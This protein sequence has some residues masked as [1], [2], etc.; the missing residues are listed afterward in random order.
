[1]KTLVC[2][3]IHDHL[4]HFE[5]VMEAALAADCSSMICCGDL[6]SPF[7]IDLIHSKW[8]GPVHIIF[9][10]ND[11]DKLTIYQKAEKANLERSPNAAI[12]IHGEFI[13]SRNGNVLDGIPH[14]ISI[15]VYHFPQPAL[16]MAESGL[17]KCVF[18]G[19][20]HKPELNKTGDCLVANPGSVMGWIPGEENTRPSFL[21]VNWENG[22]AD[23]IHL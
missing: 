17:F 1:M 16:A 15:A 20:T 11:G 14:H 3:D 2:S 7:V 18:Y 21:V 12:H 4:G 19:H 9:G 23:L 10:N 6:C 13:T 5:S 22:E 8:N